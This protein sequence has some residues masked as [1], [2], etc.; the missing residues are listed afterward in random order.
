MRTPLAS[1]LP[2]LALGA[3]ST[4]PATGSS[5]DLGTAPVADLAQPSSPA[6]LAG[7]LAPQSWSLPPFMIGPGD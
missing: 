1:L 7:S 5:S 3:C 4:A 6:D 2:A